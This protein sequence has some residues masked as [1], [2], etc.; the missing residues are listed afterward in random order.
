MRYL[1][2]HPDAFSRRWMRV[3]RLAEIDGICAHLNRQRNL[4]NG[5]DVGHVGAHLDIDADEATVSHGDTD[6][7]CAD[8][9]AVRRAQCLVKRLSGQARL[10]SHHTHAARTGDHAKCMGKFSHVVFIQHEIWVF[11]ANCYDVCTLLFTL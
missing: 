1:R 11:N 4:A 3:N 2:R 7:V 8:L 5:E 10:F 9:L 6:F